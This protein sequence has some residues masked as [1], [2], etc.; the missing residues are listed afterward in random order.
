MMVDL[1]A[2]TTPSTSG[3]H[4]ARCS[5]SPSAARDGREPTAASNYPA[6]MLID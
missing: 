3:L 2:V 4:L 5:T 1:G 6:E